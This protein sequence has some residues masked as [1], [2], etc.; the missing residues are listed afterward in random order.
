MTLTRTTTRPA[1]LA[2]RRVEEAK[3]AAHRVLQRADRVELRQLEREPD[4]REKHHVPTRE[5]SGRSPVDR[6]E[7]GRESRAMRAV[8]AVAVAALR[9]PSRENESVAPEKHAARRRGAATARLQSLPFRRALRAWCQ[10]A[11]W[12]RSAASI[13]YGRFATRSTRVAASCL[14]LPCRQ[15][16]RR[17]CDHRR[18]GRETYNA[19]KSD[20]KWPAEKLVSPIESAPVADIITQSPQFAM[21]ITHMIRNLCCALRAKHGT[22]AHVSS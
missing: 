1:D 15:T 6:P 13:W 2:E 18:S 21:R 10:R 22:N 14:S 5:T 11:I 8:G 17:T 7:R 4:R 19:M 20:D 9:R 3:V 12:T 16:R